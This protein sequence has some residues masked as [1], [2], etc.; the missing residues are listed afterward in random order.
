MAKH[1]TYNPRT[2]KLHVAGYCANSNGAGYESFPS[3]EAAISVH[4]G[5]IIF[6]I[7]C[8]RKIDALIQRDKNNQK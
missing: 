7:P 8:K 6:C 5:Q 2:H 1:Y 4:A 3:E